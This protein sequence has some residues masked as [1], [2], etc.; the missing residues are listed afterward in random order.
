MPEDGAV[1]GWIGTSFQL[2]KAAGLQ[3]VSWNPGDRVLIWVL[4]GQ[5]DAVLA[6]IHDRFPEAEVDVA[7]GRIRGTTI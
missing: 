3:A 4:P 5:R 7:E 6:L 1:Y 2:L